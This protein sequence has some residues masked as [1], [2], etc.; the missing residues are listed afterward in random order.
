MEALKQVSDYTAIF[1]QVGV[2]FFIP[3]IVIVNGS[4]FFV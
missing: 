4:V 1:C 3:V 2:N